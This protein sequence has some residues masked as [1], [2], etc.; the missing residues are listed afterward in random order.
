MHAQ[1]VSLLVIPVH[2]QTQAG[3]AHRVWD[4]RRLE[5]LDYF[6]LRLEVRDDTA[7]RHLIS[8]ALLEL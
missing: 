5:I 2:T 8:T 3:E 4:A 6:A 7:R 1:N